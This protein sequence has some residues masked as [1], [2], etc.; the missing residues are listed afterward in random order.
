[1]A[2]GRAAERALRHNGVD[3]DERAEGDCERV[4]QSGPERKP[5]RTH[6]D[7]ADAG[8]RDGEQDLL[9]RL[10]GRQRGAADA[11]PVECRH[12]GVVRRQ[13]DDPEVERRDGPPPDERRRARQEHPVDGERERGHEASVHPA[14]A[15]AG[16]SAEVLVTLTAPRPHGVD[17]PSARSAN[18]GVCC[19]VYAAID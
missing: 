2:V 3:A 9:P 1:M 14:E 10:D 12:H 6:R 17:P 13:A 11:G 16:A 7:E 18:E 19:Q 4:D 8:E 5:P 15:L